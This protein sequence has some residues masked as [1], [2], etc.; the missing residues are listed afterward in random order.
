VDGLHRGRLE[1]QVSL[2]LLH[3]FMQQKPNQ[4]ID[5][6]LL[7]SAGGCGVNWNGFSYA[8]LYIWAA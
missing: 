5:G 6:F 7:C 8:L 2:E 3:T 1:L 4:Q